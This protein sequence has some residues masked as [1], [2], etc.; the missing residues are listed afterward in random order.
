MADDL[1]RGKFGAIIAFAAVIFFLGGFYFDVATRNVIWI[2]FFFAFAGLNYWNH[3]ITSR[4]R[5][6]VTTVIFLLAGLVG[7]VNVFSGEIVQWKTIWMVTIILFVLAVP[8]AALLRGLSGR[9][10]A[11]ENNKT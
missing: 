2:V 6:L 9:R 1:F 4:Y 7:I 5:Y 8:I 3:K 11:E 10:N